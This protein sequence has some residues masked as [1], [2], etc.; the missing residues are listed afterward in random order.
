MTNKLKNSKPL[1]TYSP[2]LLTNCNPTMT[3]VKCT[4]ILMTLFLFKF[5]VM[6]NFGMFAFCL[7]S[8]YIK[9]T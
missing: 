5:N 3:S 8:L 4:K 2:E 6:I 1:I 9:N 7:G